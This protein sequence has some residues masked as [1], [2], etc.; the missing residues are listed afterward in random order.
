M[1]HIVDIKKVL[2]QQGRESFYV[3]T[4]YVWQSS[5][6]KIHN[7]IVIFV[8]PHG[9]LNFIFMEWC[10]HLSIYDVIFIEV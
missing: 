10:Y 2:Q 7:F 8:V 4:Y 9:F 6:A 1:V 5:N 3:M